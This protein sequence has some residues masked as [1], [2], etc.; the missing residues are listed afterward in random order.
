MTEVKIIGKN[1]TDKCIKCGT[2]L[3]HSTD[4]AIEDEGY[5]IICNDCRDDIG[6][7]GTYDADI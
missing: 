4:H 3:P 5:M 1:K 2:E 7:G 6:N